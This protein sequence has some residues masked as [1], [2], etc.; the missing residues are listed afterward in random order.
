MIT[1][2]PTV[3]FQRRPARPHLVV[4]GWIRVDCLTINWMVNIEPKKHSSNPEIKN[5]NT[6]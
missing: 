2:C 5:W 3:C 4:G 1:E 6:L